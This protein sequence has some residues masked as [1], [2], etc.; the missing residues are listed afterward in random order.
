MNFTPTATGL[1]RRLEGLRLAAYRDGA[2][3]PTIGYGH[4]GPEVHDGL[5]WT[6]GQVEAAFTTD[7][8][9]FAIG[10]Q[11]MLAVHLTDNQF[12]ALVIFAYNIGL[13]ALK[14]STALRLINGG[15]PSMALESWA[16]W[17]H[18][19]KDGVLVVDPGLQARRQAEIDLWRS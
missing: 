5:V 12:S 7:V 19:H 3:V 13:N 8:A 11:Q 17:N 18:I 10:V 6:V 4:T 16:S 2:G 14:G 15:V 9:R 1:L